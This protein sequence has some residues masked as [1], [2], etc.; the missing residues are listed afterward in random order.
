[1]GPQLAR[2]LLSR[3]RTAFVSLSETRVLML[4]RSGGVYGVMKTRRGLG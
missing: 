3:A 1:M 2:A 4:R